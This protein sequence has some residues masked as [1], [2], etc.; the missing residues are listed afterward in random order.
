MSAFLVLPQ[1]AVTEFKLQAGTIDS[2][3]SPL[4]QPPSVE[5]GLYSGFRA[6]ENTA[7]LT[8][9]VLPRKADVPHA[10]EAS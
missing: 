2:E 1:L 4:H 6:D 10:R 3:G 8:A 5:C 7:D 9:L